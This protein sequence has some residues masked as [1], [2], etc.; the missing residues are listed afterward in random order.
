[1]QRKELDHIPN[2]KVNV[3]HFPRLHHN[4]STCSWKK[5][6]RSVGY[7][8][9]VFSTVAM[10]STDGLCIAEHRILDPFVFL[11]LQQIARMIWISRRV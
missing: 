4:H 6:Q 8:K 2:L 1:M 11:L 3:N 10:F 7:S 9:V 5:T